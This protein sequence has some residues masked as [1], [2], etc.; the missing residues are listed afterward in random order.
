MSLSDRKLPSPAEFAAYADRFSNWGR[1]GSLDRLGTLN[2]ITPDVRRRAAAL[3][4]EGQVVSLSLPISDRAVRGATASGLRLTLTTSALG[5]RDE[6]SF[7]QHGLA[8]TH[9]DALRH[10][11]AQPGG[12]LYNGIRVSEAMLD[13]TGEGDITAYSS[14][15]VTRGVLYDVPRFRGTRH[16]TVVDPVQ[17]WE[18]RKIA[19]QQGVEPEPGD[20]VVIRCG[21]ASYFAGSRGQTDA[22][23]PGV[24]ASVLEFLYQTKASVLVW[25]LLDAQRQELSDG[26]LIQ[27][28]SPIH[29]IAI[30]FMGMPLVD[31]A[32]LEEL[33]EVC[34]ARKRAEFLLVVAPLPVVRATGSPVNPLA[35][36]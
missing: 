2:F 24:H 3:V 34:R 10:S 19:I 23:R 29:R 36:F 22:E 9:I 21:A 18:L 7:E 6:L 4:S 25:D 17:G 32:E 15:I 14:G 16:V 27:E 13:T 5:A 26:S 31:N 33:G 30:P 8:V 20:A 1:W 11:F 28:R 35:F 12:W